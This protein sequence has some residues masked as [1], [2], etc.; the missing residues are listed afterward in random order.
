MLFVRP[1]Q[2]DAPKNRSQRPRDQRSAGAQ[3]SRPAEPRKSAPSRRDTSGAAG[4]GAAGAAGR[5]SAGAAG[6]G[7]SSGQRRGERGAAGG[8]RP[9]S[10]KSGGTRGTGP[11]KRRPV[12]DGR[13]PQAARRPRT[14]AGPASDNK[15]QST[16]LRVQ[17]RQRR[18]AAAQSAQSRRKFVVLAL[19]LAALLIVGV[20]VFHLLGNRGSQVASQQEHPTERWSPVACSPETLKTTVEAP[21]TA[22]A[23]SPV[24]FAVNVENLSDQHPCSL[25]V[26]WSNVDISVSSGTDSVF[27]TQVCQFG[28]ENK[29]LLLDR[30]MTTSFSFTWQGG[31]GDEVCATPTAS[32]SQPG[33]YQ[34]KLTFTDNAAGSAQTAFVLQ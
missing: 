24:T 34:A 8:A 22:T 17:E 20:F 16:R 11:S 26:G 31:I 15:S 13:Q 6:R 23:G 18:M 7:A 5:G 12:S 28:E 29:R 4:R 9:T 33:S 14:S 25:N 2:P 19:I 30:S 32:W 3:G 21:L 1:D 10:D 27:S